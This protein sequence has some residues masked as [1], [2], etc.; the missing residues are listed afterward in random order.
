MLNSFQG[1]WENFNNADSHDESELYNSKTSEFWS[2]ILEKEHKKGII[3][4]CD[5]EPPS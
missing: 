3:F 2:I 1:I 4:K 5:D